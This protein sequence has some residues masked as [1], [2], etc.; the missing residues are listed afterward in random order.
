MAEALDLHSVIKMITNVLLPVVFFSTTVRNGSQ[1][2]SVSE[3]DTDNP[4]PVIEEVKETE[5]KDI[6]EKSFPATVELN[7][8][9]DM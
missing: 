3:T 8:T 6:V 1:S 5:M 9:E 2:S 7:N 4:L